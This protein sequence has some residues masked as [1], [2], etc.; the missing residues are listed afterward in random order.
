MKLLLY[1][2]LC[3]DLVQC[4]NDINFCP[5]EGII[6]DAINSFFLVK[7]S[8]NLRWFE[9]I[10]RERYRREVFGDYNTA[11]WKLSNPRK[12]VFKKLEVVILTE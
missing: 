7:T 4:A 12:E 1:K 6:N 3:Y 11:Y 10:R 9:T 2:P 5:D 8:I